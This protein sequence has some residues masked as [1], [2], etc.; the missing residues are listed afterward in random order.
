M[1]QRPNDTLLL[2]EL[3]YIMF[4]E[5][6]LVAQPERTHSVGQDDSKTSKMWNL[7]QS[8]V[9]R[10]S[11]IATPFSEAAVLEAPLTD[12]TLNTEVS[13]L[14]FPRTS[15]NQCDSLCDATGLCGLTYDKNMRLPGPVL[16]CNSFILP[17]T[18]HHT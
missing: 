13:T 10:I 7:L 17:Q 11:S 5:V 8:A 6:L 1:A 14:A 18:L 3:N 12:C 9:R 2:E 4:I 15:F 16:L